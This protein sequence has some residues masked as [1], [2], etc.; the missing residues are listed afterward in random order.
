MSAAL[1]ARAAQLQGRHT[2]AERALAA[3]QAEVQRLAAVG[4]AAT[5]AAQLLAAFLDQRR[6]AVGAAL[7]GAITAGLQQVFGP[8]LTAEFGADGKPRAVIH[9]AQTG[10]GGDA[11]RGHG[12]SGYTVAG[13]C[14]TVELLWLAHQTHGLAPLL[15]WDEPLGALSEDRLDQAAAMF[16]A[17][18]DLGIQTILITNYPGM[19]QHPGITTID[20]TE[21]S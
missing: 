11:R 19:A 10:F 4:V 18:A 17:L 12:A 13:F 9:D 2:Q 8:H 5:G 14:A 20:V 16:A 6:G 7:G 1:L 3:A 21:G 15:V